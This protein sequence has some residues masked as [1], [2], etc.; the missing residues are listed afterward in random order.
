MIPIFRPQLRHPVPIRLPQRERRHNLYA[1]F[2]S[3]PVLPHLIEVFV[4]AGLVD[5]ETSQALPDH[6]RAGFELA[7]HHGIRSGAAHAR[8]VVAPA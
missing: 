7:M 4:D 2:R 1:G 5:I 8:Y 3:V 6:L